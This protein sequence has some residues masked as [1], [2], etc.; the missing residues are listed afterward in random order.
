LSVIGVG[1]VGGVGGE[2]G[3]DIADRS[4]LDYSWFASMSKFTPGV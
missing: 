2:D 3:G 1:G 4:T